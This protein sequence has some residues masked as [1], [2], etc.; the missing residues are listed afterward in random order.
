MESFCFLNLPFHGKKA[1]RKPWVRLQRKWVLLMFCIFF[2]VVSHI[3]T[4]AIRTLWAVWNWVTGWKNQRTVLSWCL[5]ICF[6]FFLI[7]RVFLIF[8]LFFLSVS[9][10]AQYQRL[11]TYNPGPVCHTQVDWLA[12]PHG[13]GWVKKKW[14]SHVVRFAT[15]YHL[16]NLKNVKNTHGGELIL[17]KLKPATL[18]KL[19]LFHGCFL[20]FLNCTNGTKSGNAPHVFDSRK[21]I[22]W[23]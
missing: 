21:R 5:S 20:R 11:S 10:E 22:T 18:L 12:E 13:S 4:L 3:Q 9:S 23:Q 6:T 19:T 2:H 16:C 8:K 17:V 1:L 7:S 15:W 14:I